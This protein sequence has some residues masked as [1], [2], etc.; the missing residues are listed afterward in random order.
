M[1]RVDASKADAGAR[2]GLLQVPVVAAGGF[3]QNQPGGG[4]FRHPFADRRRRVGNAAGLAVE[5]VEMVFR[6]I[7]TD[8]ARCYDHRPVPV[9]RGPCERPRSTVQV[10]MQS[11]GDPSPVTV[12]GDQGSNGLPSD[13]TQA[14][15]LHTGIQTTRP[16]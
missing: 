13:L 4:Q 5:D 12:C 2:Q 3:E 9:L 16:M 15:F 6:D 14:H 7:D 11:E 10:K 8:V 1:Q